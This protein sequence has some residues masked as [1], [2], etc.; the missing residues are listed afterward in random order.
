MEAAECPRR[1]DIVWEEA[2]K[3]E[4]PICGRRGQGVLGGVGRCQG[5]GE[6]IGGDLGEEGGEEGE[7]QEVSVMG[8]GDGDVDLGLFPASPAA[9]CTVGCH[10]R[11]DL[12][13]GMDVCVLCHEILIRPESEFRFPGGKG[14]DLYIDPTALRSGPRQADAVVLPR[15]SASVVQDQRQ[16]GERRRVQ[17]DILSTS[18]NDTLA[19]SGKYRGES[20]IVVGSAAH[21]AQREREWRSR[22][23]LR[24]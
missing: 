15:L 8:D 17:P 6:G 5:I 10:L 7:E 9:G 20:R 13:F 11:E 23:P 24:E 21:W 16:H 19:V 1:Y 12:G 18:D 3:G 2:E 4:C 14:H 22:G